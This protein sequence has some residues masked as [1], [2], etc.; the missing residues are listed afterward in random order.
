M[1]EVEFAR[2]SGSSFNVHYVHEDGTPA[3]SSE[4][5]QQGFF[6]PA[7]AAKA[8]SYLLRGFANVSKGASDVAR[9]T[10]LVF[11]LAIDSREDMVSLTQP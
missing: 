4:V 10:R 1:I 8:V 11:D 5:D 9:P 2:A 6:V 3:H 7:R